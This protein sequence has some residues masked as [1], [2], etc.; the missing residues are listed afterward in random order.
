MTVIK[1]IEKDF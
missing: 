1:V